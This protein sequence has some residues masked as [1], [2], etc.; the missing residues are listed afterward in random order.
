MLN[1][2]AN[3]YLGL[4][5]HPDIVAA[6]GSAMD[7]YGFGMAS[8]RFICGTLDLH[9]RLE[10]QIADWLG[11]DD[12]ILFAAC[13]DANGAVFEPPETPA[14]YPRVLSAHRRPHA[15]ADGFDSNALGHLFQGV[16]GALGLDVRPEQFDERRGLAGF[17]RH[18]IVDS[19]Q[20]RDH[21]HALFAGVD[22]RLTVRVGTN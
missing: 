13:F 18:H 3:N 4:A 8:V 12:S 11:H 17:Q 15:T 16:V 9:R 14:G 10:H 19:V 22:R 2:C 20:C 6:A 21:F 1:L 7:R 5:D